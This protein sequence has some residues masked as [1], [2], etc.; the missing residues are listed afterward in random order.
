MTKTYTEMSPFE[1]DE[2]RER[3]GELIA[4]EISEEDAFFVMIIS[5][6]DRIG[7]TIGT[8]HNIQLEESPGL[9]REVADEIEQQIR[10]RN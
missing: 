10:E 5:A 3:I 7:K 6:S 8:R 1:R 2:L 9:L 4:N